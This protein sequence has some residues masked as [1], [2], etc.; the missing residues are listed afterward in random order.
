MTWVSLSAAIVGAG[1][2]LALLAGFI[3]YA[4]LRSY[5]A[6]SERTYMTHD[7]RGFN[8]ALAGKGVRWDCEVSLGK[9]A[10]A[11]RVEY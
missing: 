1:V 3:V 7:E 9:G 6:R 2:A 8:R 10:G 5:I 11:P 4:V